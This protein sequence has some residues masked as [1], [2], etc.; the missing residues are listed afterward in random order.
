MR[1]T[2]RRSVPGRDRLNS[3]VPVWHPLH[4]CELLILIEKAVKLPSALQVFDSSVGKRLG[5]TIRDNAQNVIQI[6]E[7]LLQRR[8]LEGRR[9][10]VFICE[11]SQILSRTVEGK[12]HTLI[13]L[14]NALLVKPELIGMPTRNLA[15]AVLEAML[16]QQTGRPL[17]GEFSGYFSRLPMRLRRSRI[18]LPGPIRRSR[19]FRA[20]SAEMPL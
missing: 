3:T 12:V 17:R 20:R 7:I 14:I 15:M 2:S 4:F 13:H 1:N 18:D 19:R 10:R 5:R 6:Q 16:G 11:I 9:N 8:Y